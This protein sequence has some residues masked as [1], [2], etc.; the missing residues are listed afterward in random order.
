MGY[1]AY[2]LIADWPALV[3]ARREH[4]GDDLWWAVREEL[5]F[6]T[7]RDFVGGWAFQAAAFV[8]EQLR[9]AL[10][11]DLLARVDPLLGALLADGGPDD[12][13]E[14]AGRDLS[15]A[16]YAMRPERVTALAATDLPWDH[17]RTASAGVRYI[18]PDHV[19]DFDTFRWVVDQ[20]TAWLGE[21]RDRGRGLAVVVSF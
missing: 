19:R 3:A 4:E 5:P 18:D 21:A 15:G 12:L 16:V 20:Q 2:A 11:P 10:T 9:A 1:D 14:D 8:Y 17:L 7:V 13:A 6:L